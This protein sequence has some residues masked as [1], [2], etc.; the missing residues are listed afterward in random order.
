MRGV[1]VGGS[2]AN[3]VLQGFRVFV[4]GVTFI[5][6]VTDLRFYIYCRG[7]LALR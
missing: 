3:F 5:V 2:L 6:Q 1:T 4:R 7:F